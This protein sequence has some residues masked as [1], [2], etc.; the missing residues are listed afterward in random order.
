MRIRPGVVLAG[1]VLCLNG[2]V[3]RDAAI[4]IG[5][6]YGTEQAVLGEIIAQ[7]V[8]RRL[9][10]PVS[11]RM[12]LG[13]SQLLHQALIS[14][15][16]D[17]Y[18]EYTGTALR[19]ILKLNMEH[20]AATVYERVRDLYAAQYQ[21]V[22]LPPFGFDAAVLAAV[23]PERAEMYHLQKM[24][25]L[26]SNGLDWTIAYS[27]S[28]ASRP[29]G[30]PELIAGY[31]PNIRTAPV[32]LEPMALFRAF[33]SKMANLIVVRRTDGPISNLKAALLADD[34]LVFPPYQGFV[35]ARAATL[36]TYPQLNVA[37]RELSGKI[38]TGTMQRLNAE[39]DLE[40]QSP[41]VVA[42]NFLEKAGISR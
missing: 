5:S 2:C 32:P 13:D 31:H 21:V 30:L 11:R 40:H 41:A 24:S 36:K 19:D 25:D 16:V 14:G 23:E 37:L 18:P 7:H 1:V 9:G 27:G 22:C 3:K 42:R 20:D 26:D 17:L 33:D 10:R 6:T 12:S 34:L 4:S 15:E 8:E 38:D 35:A 39:V 28:F 29:D